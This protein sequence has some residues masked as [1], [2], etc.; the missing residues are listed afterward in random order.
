MTVW[1]G[2]WGSFSQDPSTDADKLDR[3]TDAQD[4]HRWGG[5][6]W[7]WKQACGDPHVIHEPGG[8]PDSVSPSLIRYSCPEQTPYDSVAP[9]YGE[10]LFRP[11][12]RAV[13][14]TITRLR[15]DGRTGTLDLAGS[16]EKGADGC[17]L[18]VFVP[19]VWADTTRPRPRGSSGLVA[20]DRSRQRD[21]D[22]AAS[23]RSSRSASAET[24]DLRHSAS[25]RVWP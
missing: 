2:E 7:D 3:F 4:A 14:G 9:A 11:L 10:A 23:P 12:P 16:R 22:A 19:A 20:T 5:A 18:R 13:P 8:L 24:G 21:P 6:W 25:P 1:I 15:S 17:A